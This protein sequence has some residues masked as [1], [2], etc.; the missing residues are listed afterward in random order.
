MESKP[1]LLLEI[2]ETK[3]LPSKEPIEITV[4]GYENSPRK[5]GDGLVIFG[6]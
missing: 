2:L 3:E 6:T 1:K 4:R 5:Y